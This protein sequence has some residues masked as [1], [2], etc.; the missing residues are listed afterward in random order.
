MAGSIQASLA[1]RHG[2]LQIWKMKQDH[3]CSRTLSGAMFS[4]HLGI[5]AA[6]TWCEYV[7]RSSTRSQKT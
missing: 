4:E 1:K 7:E 2:H 5:G 6:R 3:H